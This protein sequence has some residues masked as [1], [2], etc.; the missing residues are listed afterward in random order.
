MNFCLLPD[1]FP[2]EFEDTKFFSNLFDGYWKLGS[3][4]F[5]NP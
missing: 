5:G 3:P 2:Q 1:D 4:N